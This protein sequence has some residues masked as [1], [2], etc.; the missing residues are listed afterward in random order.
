MSDDLHARIEA[1]EISFSHQDSTLEE[2]TLV[3]LA[4]EKLVKQQGLLIEHLEKKLSSLTASPDGASQDEA[5]P[6]HY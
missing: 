2:L 1:L 3:L 6:P 4:Q 5:P